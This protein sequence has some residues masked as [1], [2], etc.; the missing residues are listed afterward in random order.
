MRSTMFLSGLAVAGLIVGAVPASAETVNY[1]A[2]VLPASEVPPV[3]NSQAMGQLAATY[4][5]VTKVL[6][7][8]AT[9]SGLTGPATMAHFHGPAPVG[10]AAGVMVPI[11]GDL[12]SPIKGSA[13]LTDEQAK[14]L[15]EGNMYFNIHTPTNKAGELR[16]Q[17]L[18]AD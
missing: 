9:Y 14:A 18:K 16:G 8:T 10:K 13:T 5:T 1:K 17:V 11:N 6:T 15:T 7:Y 12:A 2:T 4:D 3:T